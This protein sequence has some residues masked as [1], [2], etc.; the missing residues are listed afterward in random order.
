MNLRG[1][2]VSGYQ[3]TINWGLVAKSDVDFAILKIVRKD[4]Q[5]DKQFEA[6]W[7]GATEAGVPVQGVYNYSYATTI[8]KFISDAKRVI[9]ILNAR[10]AM[11]WLDVEDAG[12]KTIGK[13]LIDGINAYGKVITEAGLPFGIYTGLSFYNSFIKPF[14]AEISYPFWIARYP[15]NLQM[16]IG[17]SLDYDKKP[18]IDHELYGW[19]YSSKGVVPGVKGNVDMNELY[20]AVDTPNVMPEPEKTLH[21]VGED[22]TVSS[23]Y[24]SS[25]DPIAKAIY[26]N[27]RG[28]IMR[29]KAGTVNPYCF[30]NKGVPIGWCND[31]DIRAVGETKPEEKIH[32]VKRGETL[33]KIAKMYST[34][35]SEIQKLNRISNP[36]RIY[37]NQKIRI[38]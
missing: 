6:N 3:G 14:S 16:S 8:E 7:V 22:I 23:Y 5:A 25:T 10:K 38:S 24:A 27:A 19:Q 34:T 20:V 13:T 4:M 1:I 29:V 30:G 18:S 2:D 37:V 26:K 33:A 35:V 11:V 12:L 31:G 32:V 28:V 9:E 36:N 17:R 15:S 21:K